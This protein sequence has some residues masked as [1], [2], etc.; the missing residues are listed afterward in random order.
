MTKPKTIV[1]SGTP[2]TGKTLFAK[3][4]AKELGFRYISIDNLSKSI[5]TGYDKARKTKIVDTGRMTAAFQQFLKNS[6]DKGIIFES[7]LAHHL[8]M[9]LVTLCIIL[10]TDIKALKQRLAKR[11]YPSSKIQE[12][13]HAEIF[14]TCY[15]EALEQNHNVIKVDTTKFDKKKLMNVIFVQFNKI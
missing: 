3:K 5:Y 12:N 9:K 13:L 10:T 11:K 7:H 14:E 8:P 1:V 2:G 4:L 6:N 15:N